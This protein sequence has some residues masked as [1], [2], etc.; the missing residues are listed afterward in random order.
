MPPLGT[1]AGHFST[2]GA[3][4]GAILAPRDHPGGPWEQHDK[5]ER[6]NRI[7]IDFWHDFG[8]RVCSLFDFKKFDFCF[9]GFVSRSLV[10]SISGST[11]R[12]LGL[13]IR[14]FR[15]ES[16]AKTN[17]SQKSFCMN[18]GVDFLFVWR[19]WDQFFWCF[20]PWKQA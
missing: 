6:K 1:P 15:K 11:F 20:V 16:I 7:F 14:C 2:S 9:F 10:L 4:R 19:P 13:S 17:L 18:F 3:L 12:G 8:T 5:H